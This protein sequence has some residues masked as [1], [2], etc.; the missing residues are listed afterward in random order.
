MHPISQTTKT[1]EM[2]TPWE[3]HFTIGEL[4]AL[5]GYGRTTIRRWFENEPG[6][7]KQGESRLRRGR[8]RPYVSLRVPESIARRVYAKHTEVG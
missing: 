6:V 8:K 5:W 3:R 2:Q 1:P 4:T 7:L